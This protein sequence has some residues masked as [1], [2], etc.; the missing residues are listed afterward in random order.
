[1]T[2]YV[3]PPRDEITSVAATFGVGTVVLMVFP[4]GDGVVIPT[5]LAIGG[6][7]H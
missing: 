5:A 4:R 3:S 6:S 2:G 7:R 1:M